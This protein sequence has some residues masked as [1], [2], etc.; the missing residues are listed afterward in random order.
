M[1]G[2]EGLG[3]RGKRGEVRV[4]RSGRGHDDLEGGLL[5]ERGTPGGRRWSRS[6]GAALFLNDGVEDGHE[7]GEEGRDLLCHE[8]EEGLATCG[9]QEVGARTAQLL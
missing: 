5:S 7:D 8:R 3:G 4:R 9:G 1:D 2:Q 6:D